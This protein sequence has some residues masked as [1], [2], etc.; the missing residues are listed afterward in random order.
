MY[1]NVQLTGTTSG[2]WTAGEKITQANTTAYGYVISSNS[3]AVL[4][5]NVYGQFVVGNTTNNANVSGADSSAT[6]NVSSFFVNTSEGVRSSFDTFDQ[7]YIFS[8]N[9]T[10]SS[11]YQED[12]KIVQ[13]DTNANAYVHFA[14]STTVAVTSQ[15]GVF[16]LAT[17]N[18]VTGQTTLR[19]SK[20]TAQTNPD[21][22]RNAGEVLYLNNIDAVSRSNTTTE[23]V[24]LVITF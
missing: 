12:E 24:R 22:V 13:D 10:S 4:V 14:N 7:R 16:N 21:L 19:T 11:T 3:T 8:Q 15:K 23:T 17:D 9:T 1:S 20:L 5:S 2:T 6:M 18:V